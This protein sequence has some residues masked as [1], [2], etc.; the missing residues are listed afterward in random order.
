MTPL[1]RAD[2]TEPAVASAGQAAA[3]TR[4]DEQKPASPIS[5]VRTDFRN[6]AVTVPSA[7]PRAQSDPRPHYKTALQQDEF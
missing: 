4:I 7:T 2:A 6:D 1:I 5:G 3:L